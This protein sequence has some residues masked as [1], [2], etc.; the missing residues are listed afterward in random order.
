M[1]AGLI[2]LAAWGAIDAMHEYAK[3]LPQISIDKKFHFTDSVTGAEMKIP[4]G[5]MFGK[6]KHNYS[7]LSFLLQGEAIVRSGDEILHLTAPAII[8]VKADVWHSCEAVTDVIWVCVHST[9]E[10]DVTH[11]E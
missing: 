3:T 1:P 10:T 8:D 7:H 11:H 4:A 5:A 9:K 6:E 2:P